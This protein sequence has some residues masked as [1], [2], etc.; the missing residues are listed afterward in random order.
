MS[1]HPK[2]KT[3]V[4]AALACALGLGTVA[5]AWQAKGADPSQAAG[6]HSSFALFQEMHANA[7]LDNLPVQ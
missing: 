4:V 3:M 6:K 7:H 2:S 5:I 1:T